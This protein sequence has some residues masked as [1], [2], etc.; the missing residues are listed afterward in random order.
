MSK[1]IDAV[2][3]LTPKQLAQLNAF[4]DG[5][6]TERDLAALKVSGQLGKTLRGIQIE[7]KIEELFRQFQKSG[8]TNITMFARYFSWISGAWLNTGKLPG[9]PSTMAGFLKYEETLRTWVY[10]TESE[11]TQK[12]RHP[13]MMEIVSIIDRVSMMV[14]E[15]KQAKQ[16]SEASETSVK[17]AKQA[18]QAA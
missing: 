8:C 2:S 15:A 18:K 9:C 3:L 17:Q 6:T 14:S 13:K 5:T 1:I 4:N 10:S 11:K 16:A 12:A 7:V